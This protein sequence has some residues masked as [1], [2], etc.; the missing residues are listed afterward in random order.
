MGPPPPSEVVNA[1]AE[2]VEE[3]PSFELI[4]VP[5]PTIFY[6]FPVPVPPEFIKPQPEINYPLIGSLIAVIAAIAIAVIIV[7]IIFR[8]KA[9]KRSKSAMTLTPYS[10]TDD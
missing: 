8:R 6:F 10:P 1:P 2:I 7:V 4:D 9:K 3:A 5:E